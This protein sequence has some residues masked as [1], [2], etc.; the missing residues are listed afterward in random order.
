MADVEE[1]RKQVKLLIRMVIV[2]GGGITESFDTCVVSLRK[3]KKEEGL[4]KRRNFTAGEEQQTQAPAS[5]QSE[6]ASV[7]ASTVS[8]IP[9]L[10]QGLLNSVDQANQLQC[11]K[12]FRKLLSCEQ[13]PPV[14]ACIDCGALPLFVKF[15]E[16][17]DNPLLQFE[18][19]WALTN[20]ASTDKTHVVVESGALQLLVQL[21]MS[22]N[23]DLREQCAWCLGN[24]AGDDPRYRDIV[25]GL[26]ALEPLV[27]NVSQPASISLLRNCT[28]TLSNFCRG[29]P[30]P[31]THLVAPALPVLAHVLANSNDQDTIIDA[32]WALSYLSDGDN[33]RIQSVV[34][35]GVIPTL[36]AMLQSTKNQ[37]I[38]PALRT[39]GNIVSGNDKQT[40]AVIDALV[41]PALLPLLQHAKK[42]IRKE[43]CWMISNIAAGTSVQLQALLSTPD[44]LPRVLAQ[45]SSSAEWDVRKEASW[46]ISNIATGGSKAHIR[47]LVEHGAVQPVCDLLE[48]GEAR[49]LLMALE[50]LECLLRACG[51]DH[52]TETL[53]R[54][55]RLVEECGGLSKL[56]QLQEHENEDIYKRSLALLEKY[57]GAE[58][59][60]VSENVAPLVAQ[61]Q[62][63]FSF[64]TTN[65]QQQQFSFG[66]PSKINGAFAQQQQQSTV[67]QFGQQPAFSF[68]QQQ[69]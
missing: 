25:L 46:V 36:L 11:L 64:G 40:Q 58:E 63:T 59:E 56:E 31:A 29:K 50:T 54:V 69:F 49:M 13:N 19:A 38:V 2:Y 44:V 9:A 60:D 68:G 61:S 67:F 8:D 55:L 22:P 6:I 23:A 32:T 21:L 43:A 51:E 5:V 48:V 42:N 1:K 20:I 24:I 12:Q 16:R 66:A 37:F 10:M 53:S 39:L 35:L 65:T 34:D 62:S 26:N 27:M 18:A 52:H 47:L 28:W 33:S 57:F 30:Q 4:A 14:Q 17:N 41:I 45:M 7:V 3:D 15:L